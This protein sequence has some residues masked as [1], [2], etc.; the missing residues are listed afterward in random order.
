MLQN[1]KQDMD[2]SNLKDRDLG[3]NM[4][5]G[6]A[7]SVEWDTSQILLRSNHRLMSTAVLQKLV[8][9]YFMCST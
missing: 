1:S 6:Q 3:N 2:K 9:M 4:C 5:D 7:S 8:Q